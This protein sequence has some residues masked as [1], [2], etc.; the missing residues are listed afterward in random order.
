M[1]PVRGAR[2]PAKSRSA[3]ATFR[4]SRPPLRHRQIS[5]G[6]R[7]PPSCRQPTRPITQY[8][9]LLGPKGPPGRFK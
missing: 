3:P 7:S 8:C 4:R 9:R 6:P 5:P 1:A 2:W